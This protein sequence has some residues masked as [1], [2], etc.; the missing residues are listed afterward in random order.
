MN[1]NY[2][3]P[4]DKLLTYGDARSFREWPNYLELGLT[5]KHIPELIR[6]ATDKDLNSADS[7]SLEV[8]APLHAWRALGQLRAPEAIEPLLELFADSEDDDWVGSELPDV[9]GMIGAAA[10]P[11]LARYLADA[12]HGLFPRVFAAESL[13]RIAHRNPNARAE[14]VSVLTEQLSRFTENDPTFN[15]FLIGDL[16]DL[17]AVESLSTIRE[18]FEQECVDLTIQGDVED[19]EITLGLREQRSTPATYPSFLEK[20]FSDQAK[21]ASAPEPIRKE[22]KVGRNDPCPCGSGKK[23]KK[24]C[25]R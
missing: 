24:C 23:Y 19:V 6:M 8:W 18:A 12:S 21:A 22:P 10:I 11:A 5:R 4:V 20:R 9:Y 1:V 17:E 2:S 7:E 3:P 16:V 25:L 15:A 14:C 13:Q